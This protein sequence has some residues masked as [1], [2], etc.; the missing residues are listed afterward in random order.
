MA[1]CIINDYERLHHE[2]SEV[3]YVLIKYLFA[4]SHRNTE[5]SVASFPIWFWIR[6][7]S[8]MK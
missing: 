8:I 4:M 6:E 5:M 2:P 3:I 7:D 1:F